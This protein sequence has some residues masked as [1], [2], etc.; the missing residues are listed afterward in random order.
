MKSAIKAKGVLIP[1]EKELSKGSQKR[2][3]TTIKT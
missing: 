2:N 1:V 3:K